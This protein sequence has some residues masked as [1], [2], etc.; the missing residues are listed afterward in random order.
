VRQRRRDDAVTPAFADASFDALVCRHF[1]WT[2]RDLERA[3]AN[4]RRLLRPGGRLIAFDGFFFQPEPAESSQTDSD[5]NFFNRFY[6]KAARAA[7]PGWR[8][9][10]VEPLVV[11]VERAGFANVRA[12]NLDDIHRAAL[13][14]PSKQPPYALIG[15]AP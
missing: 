13:H 6:D 9:F 15:I 11:L 8:Y 7:L 14:P 3:L 12:L 2:L 10:S 5:E 1:L 4:W